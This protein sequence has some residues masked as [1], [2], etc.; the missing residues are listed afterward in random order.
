MATRPAQSA[1]T[2]LLRMSPPSGP[3]G[4]PSTIARCVLGLRASGSDVVVEVVVDVEVV[5][6]VEVGEGTKSTASRSVP[7]TLD[8]MRT[9]WTGIVG[10]F[11]RRVR[12]VRVVVGE[13]CVEENGRKLHNHLAWLLWLRP[14]ECPDRGGTDSLTTVNKDHPCL[15]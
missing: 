15:S 3:Y 2:T 13:I 5:A 1:D 11:A 7:S 9:L 4:W 10:W 14:A 6:A 12:M 8:G